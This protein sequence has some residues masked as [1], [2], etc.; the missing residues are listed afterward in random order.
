MKSLRWPL[1]VLVVVTLAACDGLVRK[2]KVDLP[3]PDTSASVEV[4][5]DGLE[6][7]YELVVK[8]GSGQAR[9]KMWTDWGPAT[10]ANFYVT[11]ENFIVVIGGHGCCYVFKVGE[12]KPP[13]IA[14]FAEYRNLD[15]ESWTYL[16]AVSKDRLGETRFF[17]PNEM[18]ECI[19]NYG[20]GGDPRRAK[21]QVP[22]EC[23][24]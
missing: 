19:S 8:N 13:R 2:I 14:D 16:G 12:K 10:R 1:L 7:R 11:P 15:S 4:W 24:S 5:S 22:G 3:F 23:A 18:R 9:T 20:V 17:T 21:F 6:S